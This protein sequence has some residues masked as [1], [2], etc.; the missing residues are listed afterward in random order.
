MTKDTNGNDVELYEPF[1]CDIQQVKS[2]EEYCETDALTGHKSCTE[3]GILRC[4]HDL[5]GVAVTDAEA[6]NKDLNKNWMCVKKEK[7]IATGNFK[8]QYKTLLQCELVEN[9]GPVT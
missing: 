7:K 4:E 2:C 9:T 1:D 3:S 5:C 6:Q 8:I